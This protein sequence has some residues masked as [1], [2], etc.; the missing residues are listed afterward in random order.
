MS[1]TEGF[2]IDNDPGLLTSE[3]GHTSA[4]GALGG[5]TGAAERLFDE[6]LAV[7]GHDLR[8]PL[9]SLQLLVHGLLRAAARGDDPAT[10]IPKLR[11]IDQMVRRQAQLIEELF[12]VSQLGTGAVPL[13]HE[14][15]DLGAVARKVA[16]E[17][18]PQL[19]AAGCALTLEGEAVVGDS[20]RA[21]LEQI[22]THLLSNALK[23]GRG[24][25]ITFLVSA[26][27]GRARLFVR[28]G[29]DGAGLGLWICRRLIEALGGTLAVER[30]PDGSA[31]TV[32]LPLDAR[33]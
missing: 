19:E 31:T 32:A 1:E 22:A 14:R 15:V 3:G 24:A 10:F 13:E 28:D 17:L 7:A 16:A 11:T 2:A 20:D 21:R 5:G 8:A 29:S 26:E 9:A 27:G 25:P 23:R 33:A 18:S 30:A 12:D 4:K 6:L